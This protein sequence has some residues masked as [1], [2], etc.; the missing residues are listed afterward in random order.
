M[1]RRSIT[2]RP[3]LRACRELVQ[4]LA[5][6]MQRYARD[7]QALYEIRLALTEA[8]SNIVLHAFAGK[9]KGRIKLRRQNILILDKRLSRSPKWKD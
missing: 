6:L 8:L 9:H 4:V 5:Q 1:L 3:N 7:E 2:I